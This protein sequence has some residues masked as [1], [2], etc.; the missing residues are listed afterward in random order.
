MNIML[1]KSQRFSNPIS[2]QELEQYYQWSDHPTCLQYDRMGDKFVNV[3]SFPFYQETPHLPI[4]QIP[5]VAEVVES[6]QEV[7]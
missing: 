1:P 4:C 2:D 6:G 7:L 5:L 3:G